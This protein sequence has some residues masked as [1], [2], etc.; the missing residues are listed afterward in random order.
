MPDTP[1]PDVDVGKI[2]TDIGAES[3]PRPV[4]TR[5]LS[6]S[7]LNIWGGRILEEYLPELRGKQ[8]IAV[9]NEMRKGNPVIGG[10]L[11]AIEMAFR[12]VKWA[13][14][15]YDDSPEAA[16][17]AA[18]QTSVRNDM[19]ITWADGIADMTTVLPFGHAP[20][21]MTFKIRNG[22]PGSN[23][24]DNKV[25][26]KSLDLVPQDTI[27]R[28]DTENPRSSNI[29]ALV[30]KAP[31]G[32]EDITIPMDKIVNFRLRREKNNP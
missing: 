31:P 8:A 19:E 27:E 25:G 4:M 26:L 20:F 23:F 21:E 11:R 30:Q 10:F 3:S 9:Y 24:N 28:W 12:S 7:G 32:Y 6:T 15:P 22:R 29:I 13:D 18:L 17:R 14:I 2:N 5:R 1:D 16:S